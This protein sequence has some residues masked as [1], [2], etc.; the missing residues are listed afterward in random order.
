MQKPN[1]VHQPFWI[2]IHVITLTDKKTNHK[3]NPQD[4]QSLFNSLSQQ[5]YEFLKLLIDNV[6]VDLSALR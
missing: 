1:D 3:L 6:F 2:A 4:D 5:W